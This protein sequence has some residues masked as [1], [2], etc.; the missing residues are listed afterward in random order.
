MFVAPG[1]AADFGPQ[2]IVN[3]LPGTIIT[4]D[5]KVMVDRLPVRILFGEH[6]PL[7]ATYYDIQECID[8]LAH[9]HTTWATTRFRCGDK[10]FDT[11]PLAVTEVGWICLCFHILKCTRSPL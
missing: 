4:P 6:T 3:A 11:M 9:V 10:I 8:N 7:H 1:F 2:G 5:T